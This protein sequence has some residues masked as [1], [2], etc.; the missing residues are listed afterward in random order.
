[1]S[2]DLRE[3]Y[4]RYLAEHRHPMNRL[5]HRIGIPLIVVTPFISALTMDWRWLVGGQVVGWAF[6][7]IG[8]RFEGN[9]PALIKRPISVLMGPL[10]VLVELGQAFGFHPAFTREKA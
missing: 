2:I 6:Q 7:L 5:T 3:E 1:M 10:M 9:R 8:H 4:S